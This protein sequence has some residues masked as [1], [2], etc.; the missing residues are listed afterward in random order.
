MYLGSLFIL[1]IA[2]LILTGYQS[3]RI[4]LKIVLN[5]I[6]IVSIPKIE[7]EE[8]MGKMVFIFLFINLFMIL[9]SERF[10]PNAKE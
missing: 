1:L 4:H 3:L 5:L 7:S 10:L 6:F 9:F 8:M 2:S